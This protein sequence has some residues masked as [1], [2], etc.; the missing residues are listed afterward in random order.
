M[1]RTCGDVERIFGNGSIGLSQFFFEHCLLPA[2][3]YFTLL[4]VYGLVFGVRLG[5]GINSDFG[6]VPLGLAL[7]LQGR[8]KELSNA[9]Q[10]LGSFRKGRNTVTVWR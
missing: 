7:C 6:I 5:G 9:W 2:R 4:S 3:L 8:F 1:Y 10:Y